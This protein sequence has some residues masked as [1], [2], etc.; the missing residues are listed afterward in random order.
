MRR[1]CWITPARSANRRSA[2]NSR[3]PV[4]PP[5]LPSVMERCRSDTEAVANGDNGIEIPR[6]QPIGHIATNAL[7]TT[8]ALRGARLA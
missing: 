6:N 2:N 3:S 8:T 7:S 4:G 5:S 1:N